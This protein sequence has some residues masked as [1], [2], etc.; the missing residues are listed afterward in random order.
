MLLEKIM[1]RGGWYRTSTR[2][3]DSESE[4][5]IKSATGGNFI[6][7]FLDSRGVAWRGFFGWIV[8]LDC[9]DWIV[10]WIGLWIESDCGLDWTGLDWTGLDWTGLDWILALNKCAATSILLFVSL[11]LSTII[12]NTVRPSTPY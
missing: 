8:W 9:L 5:A 4:S 2:T 6:S 10:D 3:E 1:I 11:D 12:K 7:T